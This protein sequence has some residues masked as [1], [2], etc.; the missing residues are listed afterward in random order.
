MLTGE[1]AKAS[2]AFAR[3]SSVAPETAKDH[4]SS[5]VLIVFRTVEV[6]WPTRKATPTMATA[7]GSNSE[8]VRQHETAAALRAPVQSPDTIESEAGKEWP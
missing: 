3:D 6:K 7:T 4:G 1:S 5:D 8:I 2:S